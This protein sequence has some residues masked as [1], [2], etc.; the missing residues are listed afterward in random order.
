M[1]DILRW[2]LEGD[3]S[4]QFMTHK[5]LLESDQSMLERLQSRIATEGFGERLLSFQNDDGHWG[6]YYYQP[7][8]TSTHYSLLDTKNLCM[9]QT[10][11]A[12]RDMVNRMFDEC[13]KIDG[14]MNLSKHEHSGDICVD[15]MVL[16]YASYFCPDEPRI[17]N[18]ATHL[19]S[20]QKN[21]GGFT[22]DVG[23]ETGDPHTT[24]CVLEG[25]REYCCSMYSDRVEEIE[26]VQAKAVEFLLSNNL[27]YDSTDK[28]FL[29][30][31]HPYRYRYDLLRALEYFACSKTP[32]DIRMQAALDWLQGKRRGDGRWYLEIQH[33]GNVHFIMEE[34]R[35]PS[36]FVTL[37]ALFILKQFDL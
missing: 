15:G 22:W 28:R 19:L 23:S 20:S 1:V 10:V 8:W 32:Y 13:M 35:N 34:L 3:I 7:K 18:L 36:R 9:P 27:F 5:L 31:S 12:C 30:L 6:L 24:I 21:D 16:N 29:K 14:G 2:L 37:K 4:V 11:K 33:K 25:L 17:I 26:M